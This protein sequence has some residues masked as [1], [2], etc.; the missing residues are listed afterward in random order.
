MGLCR[1]HLF[2][3]TGEKGEGFFINAD[4]VVS[5]HPGILKGST[6]IKTGTNDYLVSDSFESVIGILV[7]AFECP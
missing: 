7:E 5:V 4:S 3:A 6:L 1:F 2:N